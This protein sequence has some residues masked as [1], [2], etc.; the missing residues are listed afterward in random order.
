MIEGWAPA[1]DVEGHLYSGD[2]VNANLKYTGD[3]IDIS[4]CRHRR[5]LPGLRVVASIAAV[6]V[7]VASGPLAWA[8]SPENVAVVIND[9]SADSQKIG[10]AYAAARSI[11][12]S[13]VLHIRTSTEENVTRDVFLQTIEGPIG[14]AITRAQLQDR[15]LY[16]VLTKGVPIRVVGTTGQMGTMASVD[17]ELTLLYRRLTGVLER[18]EG[19]VLNP[20]FLRD[21]EISEART[22]THHS[23]DI[24][25][26]SRLDA[27]T[28]DEALSLIEKAASAKAEGQV[29]LD[30]RIDAQN[31]TGDDWLQLAS[32][33]LAD[34]GFEK[35]VVLETTT[36]PARGFM[37][38][39]G[40][41]SWGSTDPQN[42]VRISGLTFAPG[43]IAAAFVGTDARTFREPPV[44]WTPTA[45]PVNRSTWYAGSPE[46]LIG[47]LIRDGVT[48][49]A[50]YVQQPFLNGT[51]RPQI[52]FPAYYAGFNL[53]EAYY[54]AMPFLSWQMVVVGDPLCGP[55]P[56][57]VLSRSEIEEGIDELTELPALFS[58]RRL[59]TASKAAGNIPERA[60]SL[61]LRSS[62]LI[63]R[64]DTQG[65]RRALDEALEIE[66]RFPTA[67]QERALLDEAAGQHD[68]AIEGYRRI[69]D[70][71]PNHVVALNN[72]AYALA[73]HRKM[74]MEGLLLAKRAV[75]LAPTVPTVLDTLGWIQHLAGDDASAAK[76]MEQVA[77]T[78]VLNPD[79][80]LHAAIIFAAVGA[81]NAAKAQLAI[82]LKLNPALANSA[83]VKQLQARLAK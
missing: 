38:V 35:Q 52:L 74:P 40:Y 56:R 1:I 29:V 21:R 76:V 25:L 31:R 63:L 28:T 42:R 10:Q 16:L 47:D 82:A 79:I 43:A 4:R 18:P 36:K 33:R 15:I 71:D 24:F 59:A 49:A 14:R 46:S 19:P 68:A 72:L 77:K 7:L 12:D 61:V 23:F 3:G 27:F 53:V 55:F 30:Q 8:Q 64:G 39:L 13:N 57:K 22:F 58:K 26:V 51:V 48:G 45:D 9:N 65:A 83:E 44:A 69:L 73:V 2:M 34:Q 17:S 37:Q 80:R 6:A 54:L 60:V 62:G 20:Y 78:N 66:P 32:R 41:F 11:P 50:G 70:V 67:L 75:T 81:N 5:A